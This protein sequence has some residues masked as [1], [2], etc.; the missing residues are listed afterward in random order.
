MKKITA[1]LVITMIITL[2]FSGCNANTT[3]NPENQVNKINISYVKL[4]LNIPSIIEKNE[5]LFEEEFNKDDSPKL[6]RDLK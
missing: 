1:I 6:L 4:P 5:A 2:F 3:G